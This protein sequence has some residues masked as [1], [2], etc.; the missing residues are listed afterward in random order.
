MRRLALV[1][2]ALFAGLWLFSAC[3][4]KKEAPGGGPDTVTSQDVKEETREAME[5]AAAYTQEQ[6]EQFERQVQGKLDEFEDKLAELKA[7]AEKMNTEARAGLNQEIEE[8]RAKREALQ[9]D[10]RKLR[11]E[12]GKAWSDVRS[13]TQSAME[14][15]EKAFDKAMSRFK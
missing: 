1:S 9:D 12:S 15:L 3:T 11:S 2:V 6:K 7:E 4:E 10:L 8:L 13:G 5:T 14:E